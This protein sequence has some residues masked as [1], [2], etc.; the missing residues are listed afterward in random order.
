MRFARKPDHAVPVERPD[1]LSALRPDLLLKLW[2]RRPDRRGQRGRI[3]LPRQESIDRRVDDLAQA[4]LEP[5]VIEPRRLNQCYERMGVTQHKRRSDDRRGVI[6]YEPFDDL[7]LERKWL[8]CLDRTLNHQAEAAARGQYPAHLA[9]R[10][11][12]VRHEHQPE[13]AQHP[14]KICVGKRQ[15]RR[16]ALPPLQVAAYSAGNGEHAVVEL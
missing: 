6:A 5:H 8:G 12:P 2:R 11:G 1:R 3:D 13:L 14:V 16:I 10:F 15:A 7:G 9:K 4:S